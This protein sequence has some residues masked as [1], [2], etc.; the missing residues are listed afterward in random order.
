MFQ[1]DEY[2]ILI[3]GLD[4]AGK[5]TLL[6][7]IKRKYSSDY[8]GIPFE[9]ITTTVGLNIGKVELSGVKLLFWDLGGQEDLQSLWDK[10]YEE[11]HGLIF[12]IDSVDEKRLGLSCKVF[13]R[14]LQNPDLESVPLLVFLN[15]QDSQNAL[16]V[17]N[18]KNAFKDVSSQIGRRD[19]TVQPLSALD[20][21]GVE[22]G[23]DWMVRCVK[24][25]VYRPAHTKYEL[26]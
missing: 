16:T 20:G 23:I 11:C 17:E 9:K 2:Y 21:D 3:I 24:R 4:N 25:N 18:L 12:V 26:A 19:C 7:Q 13:S 15:K 8:R 6:E 1:K 14:M 5:T 22:N 10:Y